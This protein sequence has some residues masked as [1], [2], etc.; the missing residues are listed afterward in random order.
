M[1]AESALLALKDNY[2]FGE[3]L[4]LGWGKP[5][6]KT[7]GTNVT[8]D[9]NLLELQI[10]TNCIKYKIKIPSD[11]IQKQIIDRTAYYVAIYGQIFEKMVILRERENEDCENPKYFNFLANDSNDEHLYYRWRVYS[12]SMG[13]SLYKWRKV[14]FQ[15]IHNGPYWIPPPL[16]KTLDFKLEMRGNIYDDDS[17]PGIDREMDDIHI[18]ENN[19]IIVIHD[20]SHDVKERKHSSR[21]RLTARP[22]QEK[23]RNLFMSMLRQLSSERCKIKEA[24]IFC[25][26][27]S[28]RCI[29]VCEILYES[30]TLKET[31]AGKK[32]ARLFLMSDVLCNCSTS[33][34]RNASAYRSELRKHL[35]DIFHGLR[36]CYL[37]LKNG[38][39][40]DF[41]GQIECVLRVWTEH[42]IFPTFFMEELVNISKG[43]EKKQS[44]RQIFFEKMKVPVVNEKK[45]IDVK[46]YIPQKLTLNKS[47]VALRK[48]VTDIRHARL[49]RPKN[50]NSAF[51]VSAMHLK[52]SDDGEMMGV[53][54]AVTVEKE[55][56][57]AAMMSK[58]VRS[59]LNVV[60]EDVGKINKRRSRFD[61]VP[62]VRSVDHVFD[63][64]A[65]LYSMKGIAVDRKYISL[66]IPGEYDG[67]PLCVEDMKDLD[68]L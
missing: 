41:N 24:M 25:M 11:L 63:K 43:K 47:N 52:K 40:A 67:E 18:N 35:R 13:D 62:S 8:A 44:E 59:Q 10:P 64:K 7:I 61:Q 1:D 30:L 54:S 56:R 20:K 15:I 34:V 68:Q 2:L 66:P 31:S 58:S 26:D 14:P 51:T 3:R 21:K 36:E 23:D 17:V 33:L 27:H 42:H 9:V 48:S 45:N 32:I 4:R 38:N 29:E 53:S 39:A 16:P 22:L 46:I 55:N 6:Q 49:I 19:N 37:K 50:I 28:D 5:V 65:F 60:V 12:I 57:F